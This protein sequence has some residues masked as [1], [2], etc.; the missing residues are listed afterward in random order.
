MLGSGG[1][2]Q[3]DQ[4]GLDGRDWRM[5][6]CRRDLHR[7][8]NAGVSGQVHAVHGRAAGGEFYEHDDWLVRTADS[9]A[10]WSDEPAGQQGAEVAPCQAGIN[11]RISLA[12][13]R[14]WQWKR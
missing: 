6:E 11:L 13:L 14:E 3:R 12:S 10:A 8:H 7:L 1:E 2:L 9:H 4:A 5:S